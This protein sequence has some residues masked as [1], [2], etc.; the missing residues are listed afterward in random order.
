MA[1]DL[2]TSEFCPEVIVSSGPREGVTV[3]A[4]QEK[5]CLALDFPVVSTA[6]QDKDC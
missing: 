6:E 3:I 5:S 1:G 2:N 4:I